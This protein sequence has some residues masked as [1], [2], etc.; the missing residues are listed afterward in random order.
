MADTRFQPAP[1]VAEASYAEAMRVFADHPGQGDVERAL[2][3]LEQASS[4]GKAEAG[5]RLAA[6]HAMAANGLE[7]PRHWDQS[8]DALVEAAEHGSEAA[9]KQLLLLAEPAS[10]PFVPANVD[11]GFWLTVRSGINLDSLLACPARKTIRESPR[12]RAIEGFA[13]LNE[14]AWVIEASRGYLARATVFDHVT[15]RLIEDPARNNSAASLM[16]S[17]MDVVTEILRTRIS[18]ATR[19]P[20]RAFEPAQILRYEVGQEFVPHVDFLNP[21]K[22]GYG[23]ELAIQG[24]RIA[25]FLIYL[26]QD[27][28]GGETVFPDIGL[29]FRG[30]TGDALFWANLDQQHRPD[31][32]TKHAGLPPTSGEKWVFS[33][34]IRERPAP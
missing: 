18:F 15:G 31:P 1:A 19:V 28:G 30:R 8:F 21:D 32:L 12:I 26:G 22:P 6:F 5:E 27:Y 16:F 13:S 29:S 3:L 7:G 9:G 34:W 17:Q 33:Q 10:E 23:E 11:P 20:V 25:T 4:L 24:Q 2:D 14:C